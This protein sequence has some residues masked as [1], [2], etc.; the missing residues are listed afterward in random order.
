MGML[1]IDEH[2]EEHRVL[3]IRYPDKAVMLGQTIP[4]PGFAP[5]LLASLVANSTAACTS[6]VV[7]V[8]ATS[9]LIAATVYN[10]WKFYYPGSA[11]LAAGWYDNFSRVDAN[12]V[13]FSAPSISDFVSESVNSAAAFTSEVTFQSIT[14]PPNTLNAGDLVEIP[15]YRHSNNTSGNKGI[16]ILINS[17]ILSYQLVTST[18]SIIGVSSYGG[19]ITATSAYGFTG[20]FGTPTASAYVPTIATAT[21]QSLSLVGS[22]SAAGMT[23]GMI[24]G[25]VRI[26]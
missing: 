4:F 10:G 16:K 24:A 26:G 21:S 11:S 12:T 25:K 15:V 8:T 14:L 19:I 20:T 1:N 13:T 6:G 9:H 3:A 17:D 5:R 18:S 23:L 7:T 2:V 22:V